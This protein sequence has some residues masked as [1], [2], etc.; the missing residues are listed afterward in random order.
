[1]NPARK[2]AMSR[3]GQTIR[4]F[5]IS[6]PR[7]T[8]PLVKTRSSRYSEAS[9]VF[10]GRDGAVLVAPASS[11]EAVTHH[12]VGKQKKEDCQDSDKQ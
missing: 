11:E 7:V 6:L 3:I 4:L 5:R 9:Q 10:S 8:L 2:P 1:M 12:V